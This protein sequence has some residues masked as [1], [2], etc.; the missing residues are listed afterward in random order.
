MTSKLQQQVL[1][2]LRLRQD[3]SEDAV[4]A[5]RR[6]WVAVMLL[7]ATAAHAGSRT[8]YAGAAQANLLLNRPLQSSP[9]IM[10][11][12]SHAVGGGGGFS[13]PAMGDRKS[14]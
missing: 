8:T 6:E 14:V 13:K 12:F 3:Q 2:L 5:V 7:C 4:V 9:G 11:Y 1:L 10:L